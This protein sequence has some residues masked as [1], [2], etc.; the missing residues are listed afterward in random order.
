MGKLTKKLVDAIGDA[1]NDNDIDSVMKFF[2]EN[3]IFDHAVGPEP[4]GL[5]L[6]GANAI[7]KVFDGLFNKVENVHWK[8]LDCRIVGNKAFCEYHRSARYNDGSKEEFLSVDVLTFSKGLI[9]H[10]DTYY[11]QRV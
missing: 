6:K 9:I 4:H 10:K 8:T 7:R 5:R 3:A 1:F 2:D 11:K